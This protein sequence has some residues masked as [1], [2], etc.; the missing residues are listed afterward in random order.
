MVRIAGQDNSCKSCHLETITELGIVSPE[1][2]ANMLRHLTKSTTIFPA[3]LFSLFFIFSPETGFAGSCK[4][5]DSDLRNWEISTGF[6]FSGAKGN[7]DKTDIGARLCYE[8]DDKENRITSGA[9]YEF[10]KVDGTTNEDSWHSDLSYLRRMK[11]FS[12][13]DRSVF[14]NLSSFAERDEI[15]LISLRYG[16]GGGFSADFPLLFSIK[17]HSGVLVFLERED[18]V[19]LPADR[20]AS[21]RFITRFEK[22]SENLKTSLSSVFVLPPGETDDFRSE[23]EVLLSVPLSAI[24][25]LQLAAGLDYENKPAASS[26]EKTDF[27][28]ST[29]L[30]F[31]F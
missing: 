8:F 28:Y 3:V 12:S 10:G 22:E 29:S 26:L 13:A 4:I 5:G 27:R 11:F 1:F 20:F 18:R 21:L 9:A 30:N 14:L 2:T 25:A 31:A 24:F 16:F 6:A 7:T 23:T 17:A 15:N 19:S